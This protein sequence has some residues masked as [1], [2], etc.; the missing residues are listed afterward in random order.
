M[1]FASN[2]SRCSTAW[3]TSAAAVP[4]WVC[5]TSADMIAEKHGCVLHQST[6]N[7]SGTLS[8]FRAILLSRSAPLSWSEHRSSTGR[9]LLCYRKKRLQ[10]I[11]CFCSSFE[12]CP[13]FCCWA[14]L[15]SLFEKIE[16]PTFYECRLFL[17]CGFP[18]APLGRL[19]RF[20]AKQ[21]DRT[22][23]TGQAVKVPSRCQCRR[24][25]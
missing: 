1:R 20:C 10:S 12:V 24:Q 25:H 6:K 8:P 4:F 22:V 13:L 15:A 23:R 14:E 18:I 9:L 17:F 7:G 3:L 19:M 16:K 2:K 21:R 11:L 5:D